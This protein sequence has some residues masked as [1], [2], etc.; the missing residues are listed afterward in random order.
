M[1]AVLELAGSMQ[2]AGVLPRVRLAAGPD[3]RRRDDETGPGPHRPAMGA[4]SGG[5][6]DGVTFWALSAIDVYGATVSPGGHA[7][8]GFGRP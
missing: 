2:G 6:G 4:G 1:P 7:R 5:A 3:A 8:R